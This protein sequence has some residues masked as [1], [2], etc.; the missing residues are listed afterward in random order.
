MKNTRT[1]E[2][3]VAQMTEEQKDKIVRIGT[4]FLLA[5][6]VV[7]IPLLLFSWIG[8]WAMTEASYER[9]D[10]IFILSLS[11]GI[12]A[13]IFTIGVVLFVKL[14]YPEYSDGKRRY[15]RKERKA[16]KK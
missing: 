2:E 4:G 12:L 13:M 1:L 14:K 9:A 16:R 10:S 8:F 6:C 7:D 11:T 15:I 5:L 3:Q